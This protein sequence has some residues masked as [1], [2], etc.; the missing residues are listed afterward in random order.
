MSIELLSTISPLWAIEHSALHS[1]AFALGRKSAAKQ[2]AAR[3]SSQRPASGGVL[4]LPLWGVLTQHPSALESLFGFSFGTTTS[5]FSRSLDMALRDP[6]VST[7]VMPVN[8]PGGSVFGIEELSDQLYAARQVKPIIAVADSL[9]ASAALWIASAATKV[10]I[11]TGGEAGSVGVLALHQDFSEAEKQAGIKTS[12]IA[13][14]PKKVAGNPFEPLAPDVRAEIERD[15][16]ATYRRFLRSLA[17]NRGLTTSTVETKFGGGGMLNAREA[18]AAGMA[19]G[20]ATFPQ[21]LGTIVKGG[22]VNRRMAHL[23]AASKLAAVQGDNHDARAMASER[24]RDAE[25]RAPA[26]HTSRAA[27]LV[28][29][30]EAEGR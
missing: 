23:E 21:V 1:L 13:R 19:D 15:V 16:D 2:L 10:Y 11:T 6:Q 24:L 3:G 28:R 7:I 9:M 29:L 18:V 26:K 30:A 8:S 5:G 17:R 12:L 25:R 27:T 20:V 22:D 14:P 4:I